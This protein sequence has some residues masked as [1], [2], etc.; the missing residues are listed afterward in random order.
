MS[1]NLLSKENSSDSQV[2]HRD[3]KLDENVPRGTFSLSKDYCDK[4]DKNVPRGT[5]LLLNNYC[6]ELMKWNKSINLLSKN[7]GQS[8]QVI[9]QRHVMD[10]IQLM[11]YITQE[12]VVLDIGSG[13]GLPGI[14]LAIC[15][16][17]EVVLIEPDH[18]KCAFLRHVSAKLGVGCKV[19]VLRMEDYNHN[20]PV[21]II[22][23]R[24]FAS[25]AHIISGCMHN[26]GPKTRVVI[27]KSA[28]QIEMEVEEMA[29]L[30]HFNLQI[31]ESKVSNEG[32][33]IIF[34]DIRLK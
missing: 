20:S 27:L 24:A 18:K 14:V 29:L 2:I 19:E 21:D 7:D 22:T 15:G 17:K 32:R 16:I 23:S 13:S 26:M 1:D 3:D 5:F 34:S 9:M 33:I 30:Y 8:H 28:K 25:C 11:E 10:C 6:D 31:N 12:A 4:L